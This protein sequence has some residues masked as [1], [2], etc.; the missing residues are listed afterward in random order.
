MFLNSLLFILIAAILIIAICA[1][2]IILIFLIRKQNQQQISILQQ[3]LTAITHNN[4]I[5][6][7][8][9]ASV[10]DK[11]DSQQMQLISVEQKLDGRPI[12]SISRDPT[13]NGDN[14]TTMEIKSCIGQPICTFD[15]SDSRRN[16]PTRLSKEG[17][18]NVQALIKGMANSSQMIADGILS[19]NNFVV[20]FSKEVMTGMA[21]GT[22]PS[23]ENGT[24]AIARCGGKFKE[25]PTII[26][27]VTPIAI[28]N[29]AFI[30]WQ[31]L[32]MA[33]A[34]HYLSEINEKLESI[35]RELKEIKLKI[36]NHRLGKLQ[37]NLLYLQRCQQ[38]MEKGNL[39]FNELKN[40][41]SQ[42]ESIFRES[43][44]IINS[45]KL[46]ISSYLLNNMTSSSDN[47]DLSK[48]EKLI[49]ESLEEYNF[50]GFGISCG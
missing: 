10:S 23:L 13:F 40:Y 16:E 9:L 8:Q 27:G 22:I 31:V 43:L 37:G 3:Q 24:K 25:I 1:F 44:Q 15:F 49:S 5:Q 38:L 18:A 36:N 50:W 48:N 19:H 7:N 4:N 30:V 12:L 11:I 17:K 46:D 21:N 29:V 33:T 32:A 42:T 47:T 39:S 45:C 41:L 2:S 14:L 35:Y 26:R 20:K 28:V 6:K 34:Q